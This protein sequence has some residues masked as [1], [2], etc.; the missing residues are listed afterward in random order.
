MVISVRRER[1]GRPQRPLIVSSPID[2]CLAALPPT[3]SLR[4]EEDPP[5][6]DST[7]A[8]PVVGLQESNDVQHD[9]DEGEPHTGP[10]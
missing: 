9:G 6:D 4:D 1:R 10:L 5:V 3:R 2:E 7:Q 8:V